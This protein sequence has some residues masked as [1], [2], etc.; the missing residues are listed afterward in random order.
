MRENRASRTA[1]WVATCR[2]LGA[3]LPAD[4]QLVRDPFGL[5]FGGPA[6]RALRSALDRLPRSVAA[7]AVRA[8]APRS[9]VYWM[10][11][12]SRVIDEAVEAF[13]ASGGAQV[14]ILG[15]GFDC[16]AFRLDA[17]R[18]A[19]VFEVDH[20]A[21]QRLKRERMD[22][23]EPVAA[24]VD[25]LPWD[26]ES[27]SM[28]ELPSALAEIGHD[29]DRAT[30]T[31]WEGV[32]MYLSEPAIDA[33]VRAVRALGRSARSTLVFNYFERDALDR[34]NRGLRLA[35]AALGEPF[36]FGWHPSEL[37]RWLSARGFEVRSDR[38]DVEIA[39]DLLPHVHRPFRTLG[40]HVVIA[41]SSPAG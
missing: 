17:L 25:F 1:M 37:P 22:R 40:R 24:S 31:L 4:E 15:A 30:I 27:R 41:E 29:A 39:A 6:A 5:D 10:Q 13:A 2:G 21:T 3:Y 18:A 32:T 16:R 36:R 26:F 14:V 12:R 20:P 35:V 7:A 19:R 38:E 34:K 9:G 23:V 11:L 28:S 33:T 8:W